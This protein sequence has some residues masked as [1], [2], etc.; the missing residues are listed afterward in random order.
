MA[1]V[2]LA[3]FFLS[4]GVILYVYAGYPLM[5]FLLARL[6]PNRVQRGTN[7]PPVSVIIA[8]YNEERV[9]ER[10]IRNTLALDYPAGRLEVLIASDGSDD[11]T[12]AI[13]EEFRDTRVRL[14][15]LPR[16]GKASALNHGAAEASGEILLFTDA[17]VDL[18]PGSLKLLVALFSEPSIGGVSGRKK[19]FIRSGTDSTEKGENLYWRWDQWQK[20]QESLYGNLFAADGAVYAIRRELY[21]P[22]ED[23]AQADDIAISTRVVLQGRRLLFEPAAIAWEEAPVEGRDEFRRKVRVTN[24]SVRALLNLG[25]AL[26]TSGFYSVELLSHKLV[27]HLIP[28]FLILLVVSNAFLARERGVFFVMFCVQ[29]LFYFVALAGFATRRT[30]LGRSKWLSVPYYF[31]LVNAAAFV[32]I[33][34]IARGRRVRAWA[35]RGV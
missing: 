29:M 17:N 10:K 20:H 28:L 9:I 6:R 35:P 23:A 4:S 15:A 7:T 1:A 13:V 27:R 30:A 32:G 8:A 22:I 18:E 19:Y 16:G 25:S 24:H 34:S 5:I 3:V 26:F 14:I 12:N 31:C 11:N 21:V 33:L 2:M